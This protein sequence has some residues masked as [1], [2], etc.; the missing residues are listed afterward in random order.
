MHFKIKY[1]VFYKY[2]HYKRLSD[3]SQ[4]EVISLLTGPGWF[5]ELGIW[6]T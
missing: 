4:R 1:I 6:I 3:F 5:N 2:N